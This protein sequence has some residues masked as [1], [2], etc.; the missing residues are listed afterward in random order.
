MPRPKES[1]FVLLSHSLSCFSGNTG[2]SLFSGLQVSAA[3]P[4]LYCYCLPVQG[5]FIPHLTYCS[6]L[7]T[8]ASWY[9]PLPSHPTPTFFILYSQHNTQRETCWWISHDVVSLLQTDRFHLCQPQRLV[10]SY[11][12]FKVWSHIYLSLSVSILIFFFRST[13]FLAPLLLQMCPTCV[14]PRAS[15]YLSGTLFPLKF[16]WQSTSIYLSHFSDNNFS[17]GSDLMVL[18]KNA[19]SA[20]L[21][22]WTPLQYW[23]V[24][25][26][27]FISWYDS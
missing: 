25:Y 8:C 24:F 5:L 27:L 1:S 20:G 19:T 18:F 9:H 23:I 4:H 21:L 3:S 12:S 16:T 14:C 10:Q 7:I 22:V 15:V 11:S 13:P 6:S 2:S 17:V 26:T